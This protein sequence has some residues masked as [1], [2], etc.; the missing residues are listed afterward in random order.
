[1]SPIGIRRLFLASVGHFLG[2]HDRFLVHAGGVVVDGITLLVLGPSGAG[3]S[4]IALAALGE[5]WPVLGDDLAILRRS[6]GGI[7]AVG[8]P[9]PPTVPTDLGVSLADR[10]RPVPEDPRSRAQ[11][12]AEVL[13]TGFRRIDGIVVVGHGKGPR[14]EVTPVSGRDVHFL[15][16]GSFP[17]ASHPDQLR[18]AHP[19]FAELSRLPA[20]RLGHGVDPGQRLGSAAAA[21]LEVSRELTSRS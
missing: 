10:G 15:L 9:R 19:L 1:M 3:K 11:L 4:T 13:A 12:G 8:V 18:R 21:L 17:P 6:P 14:A 7:D 16:L 2:F 20:R 5:G